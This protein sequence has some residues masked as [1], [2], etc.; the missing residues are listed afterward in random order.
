MKKTK[1]KQAISLLLSLLMVLSVFQTASVTAFAETE[2]DFE[3]YRSWNADEVSVTRYTGASTEVTVPAELGGYPVVEV[4]YSAFRE[5]ATITKVVLPE[6]VREIGDYAFYNCTALA[7][8]DLPKDLSVIGRKAFYN[9]A[10]Y[11]N[12]S[13][14]ENDI[15]YLDSYLLDT[16]WNLSGAQTVKNGTT[17]IAN[18]AFADRGITGIS[19][20]ESVVT[21]GEYAFQNCTDLVSV[22]FSYGL[23]TISPC[24]FY[25]CTSLQ[26]AVL[27]ESLRSIGDCAFESCTALQTV[28]VPA[29]VASMG[30][31]IFYGCSALREMKGY[32]ASKAE[33]YARQYGIPFISIGMAEEKYSYAYTVLDDG[34]SI[35]ITDYYGAQTE[36]TIPAELDGYTVTE[37]AENTFRDRPEL[38]KITLPDTLQ[39]IGAD[40]FF[41]TGYY[42]NA[43]N[44]QENMLYIDQALISVPTGAAGEIAIREGTVLLADNA[45]YNCKKIT[46]VTLPSTIRYIG[47][48]AMTNCKAVA[49]LNLPEGLLRLGKSALAGCKS[50]KTLYIPASLTDMDCEFEYSSNIP[51]APFSECA[52]L[53]EI[54]VASNN[55]KFSAVDGV[56]YNKNQTKLL[57]YPR[58]KKAASF[59][60]PSSVT[61]MVYGSFSKTSALQSVQLPDSITEIAD[62]TF[63]EAASLQSIAF[64]KQL[65][66]IGS[67]ALCGVGLRA[68]AVPDSV[69]GELRLYGCDSLQSLTVG[70]G[71]TEMR[72]HD[73]PAL[74]SVAVG[75]NAHSIDFWALP[76]LQSITVSEKNTEYTTV[77][78][79]LYDKQKTELVH[80]PEDK[81]DS[82]LTIPEGVQTISD[83]SSQYIQR[84]HI[85]SS[86]D[87][88]HNWDFNCPQ[89]ESISVAEENQ[90]YS[91]QDG[92]LFNKDKTEL[93][94]YPT[95]KSQTAYTVPSSVTTLANGAFNDAVYLESLVL[96]ESITQIG[97]ALSR[98]LAL[99]AVHIPAGLTSLDSDAFLESTALESFTVAAEN[100]NY[101]AVDGILFNKA[102][103]ELIRYPAA[104]TSTSYEVPQSVTQL[105]YGAFLGADALQSVTLPTNLKA[106]PASGFQ[107]CTSL[108]SIAI[109]TGVEVLESSAFKNCQ[110]LANV[111]L[112]SGVQ[113]IEQKAFYGC[114]SL[115][116]V[117]LPETLTYL[118]WASFSNSGLEEVFIPASVSSLS[119]EWDGTAFLDCTALKQITVSPDNPTYTTQSN[120]LIEKET[121]DLLQYALASPETELTIPDTVT[122]IGRYA[123]QNADLLETV[124]IPGTVKTVNS[125]AFFDCDALKNVILS[126]G[127]ESIEDYAFIGCDSLQSIWIPRSVT[128]ISLTAFD[129]YM[130]PPSE[131]L[132][133]YGYYGSTADAFAR[134]YGYAFVDVS[135]RLQ[136]PTDEKNGVI[137]VV[138]PQTTIQMVLDAVALQAEQEII[139]VTVTE[140][141]GTVVTDYTALAQKGFVFTLTFAD[142]SVSVYEIPAVTV[143]DVNGDDKINA[144]DAR[145]VLQI[146]S[147][148]RTIDA[149]EISAADVNQD[150][151]VNAVD[152]RWI[153]QVASGARTL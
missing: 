136:V 109:P 97:T 9:T 39:R 77:N 96:P 53:T 4:G 144:V 98:C 29:G 6:S 1:S 113:R 59:S 74:V 103:T 110:A 111:S 94:L 86:M 15:L 143:G 139:A 134:A 2:G 123:F 18:D 122:N 11:N 5:N 118:G 141:D 83:V 131:K 100:P 151:K 102:K 121:G 65:T 12:E 142:N 127:V 45:M 106:I 70:N 25:K 30:D 128:Y 22:T 87:A 137:D 126:E 95:K 116:T 89:L 20:P 3:Y 35:A 99:R 114:T 14:W 93:L 36:L 62:C 76:H 75:E 41:N 125:S 84:I 46:A 17:L 69:T 115:K 49:A 47:D 68:L 112:P 37:I 8:I 71:I 52:G 24:A 150:N 73:C 32:T 107:G 79:V 91:A 16:N 132:I 61:E 101:V 135:P 34:A 149:D 63:Y 64:P 105:V 82:E 43:A 120:M 130:S 133:I 23:R 153:L 60:V 27:P 146:A 129:F 85:P 19:F 55:P 80:Y 104:K 57:Q 117:K 10:Y 50:I 66:S 40:A 119:T 38:T 140:A 33:K 21:V 78:G 81:T 148:V 56:L 58:A 42:N 48:Y 88:F 92:V 124:T 7:E 152:A 147:G 13:N 54:S 108:K 31:N 26:Q 90:N 51:A 145:W 28:T 72:V 44:W 67:E 138:L